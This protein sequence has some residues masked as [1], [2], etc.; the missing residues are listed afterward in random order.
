MCVRFVVAVPEFVSTEGLSP[1]LLFVVVR[2][3]TLN[4]SVGV[5]PQYPCPN[6]TLRLLGSPEIVTMRAGPA[7]VVLAGFSHTSAVTERKR[8]EAE[9]RE[10]H[11][12]DACPSLPRRPAHS[13]SRGPQ[14][15]WKTLPQQG[16][17]PGAG[18]RPAWSRDTNHLPY[19]FRAATSHIHLCLSQ[20]MFV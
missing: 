20:L 6:V 17:L 12:E 14:P 9:E 19:V 8:P 4:R 1:L 10:G 2:S 15:S 11:G 16:G 13:E 5:L 3:R 7:W 18:G